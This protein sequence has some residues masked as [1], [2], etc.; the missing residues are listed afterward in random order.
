KNVRLVW[1][2]SPLSGDASLTFLGADDQLVF[3]SAK[4][5]SEK[6]SE[7][8]DPT[9]VDPGTGLTRD[10]LTALLDLDPFV[11][12]VSFEGNLRFT[13]D[14]L[15]LKSIEV[16]GP[17]NIRVAVT[18]TITRDDTTQHVGTQTQIEDERPGWLSFFGLFDSVNRSTT[19]RTSQGAS[20]KASV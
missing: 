18:R 3:A 5:L 11:T 12:G 6:V 17:L 14:D 2:S 9:S 20:S 8:P 13:D 10:D 15:H 4:S 16:H 1:M 7:L 19:T